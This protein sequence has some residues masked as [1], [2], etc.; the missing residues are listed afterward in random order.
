MKKTNLFI[1]P[2]LAM[3]LVS[4]GEEINDKVNQ[5]ILNE[6][7][8]EIYYEDS[9]K[10]EAT[11]YPE[12]AINK[13]IKWET[14]NPEICNVS[15]GT[16]VPYK[17]GEAII[18]CSSVETGVSSSCVVTVTDKTTRYLTY[19]N[20]SAIADARYS[21]GFMLKTNHMSPAGVTKILDYGEKVEDTIWQMA[22]WW[23]PYDFANAT[24]SKNGS[25][26]KYEN[27]NRSLIVDTSTGKISMNLNAATEYQY[28]EDTPVDE[29]DPRLAKRAWP[30]FLIEQNFN[31]DLWVNLADLQSVSGELHVKFDVTIDKMNKI[32][33]GYA[34]DCAQLLFYLS[35]GNV[36]KEGQTD[37]EYGPNN[38]VMWF[39]VPI[40]DSRYAYTELYAQYDSGH[41]GATNR[42]IY[43]LSSKSYMGDTQ[44]EV[45]KKY[46]VD[47]NVLP[48]I[49][50]AFLMAVQKGLPSVYHWEN[51]TANYLNLGWEIPGGFDVGATFENLDVYCVY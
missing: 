39:G 20:D 45:G 7:T 43:S 50:D 29:I 44:P 19:T 34:N 16:L 25:V 40:F 28:Y 13:T 47:I 10:L 22:Q 35:I 46:S 17:A 18:T 11:V 27:E 9:F 3:S 2:I 37:E 6:T 38:A 30:H 48:Y 8:Y 4:C 21:K 24:L 14:S 31:Q 49:T 26:A 23:S 33:E 36:K 5:I 41:T 12:T 15:G 32:K 42:L 51:M 1:L